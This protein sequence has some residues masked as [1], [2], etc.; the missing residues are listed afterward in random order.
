M[1]KT[2]HCMLSEKV[3]LI[4]TGG[5]CDVVAHVQ[6]MVFTHDEGGRDKSCQYMSSIV[7]EHKV[8]RDYESTIIQA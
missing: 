5:Y 8:S 7:V 2:N 4:F 6:C 3:Q 1:V